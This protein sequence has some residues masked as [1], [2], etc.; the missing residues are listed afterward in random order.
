MQN[1]KATIGDVAKK[2]G[3][4]VATVSRVFN[5]K[6]IVGQDTYERVI[7]S[8]E[9]LNYQNGRY[10]KNADL[11]PELNKVTADDLL[12]INLPSISN[13]FYSEIVKGVQAASIRYQCD[14]LI[15]QADINESN[16]NSYISMLRRVSA[17]G[18]IVL[19]HLP[20]ALT[21]IL[22]NIIP[23]VKCCEYEEEDC[24]SSVSI[25]DLASAKNV[26]KYILSIGRRNIAFI[27][28]PLKYK[29]ARQRRDGYLSALN[30]AGIG[31]NPNWV[32]HLP[33][34]SADMAF[35]S[36]ASLLS[37]PNPPDA[38]F[39]SSDIF[40]AAVVRAA[41]FNNYRVPDDIIVVGFDN[42][43]ISSITTPSITTINQPKFQL[44]FLACEMLLEQITNPQ[45]EIQHMMLSTELI[46]RESTS[47]HRNMDY[48]N[49]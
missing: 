45:A 37:L 10:Q 39:T 24:V 16:I 42:I 40:A 14:I 1:E 13:P 3:V 32:I 26:M 21:K 17:K 43:D 20:P 9:E 11:L 48:T 2:A 6:G 46:I 34:I 38:F 4:S 47:L 15:S 33:D 28:G 29:Y 27:N 25:N 5:H 7:K 31:I 8:A 23:M 18:L 44:G 36:V 35:S 19:N 30:E 22:S 49:I 41:Q 12:I